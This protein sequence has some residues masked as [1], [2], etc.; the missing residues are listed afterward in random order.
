MPASGQPARAKAPGHLLARAVRLGHLRWYAVRPE[1]GLAFD[2]RRLVIW[3]AAFAIYAGAVTIFSGGGADGTWG[4][5]ATVGYALTADRGDSVRGVSL[6]RSSRRWP[7]RCW[8]PWS[9]WPYA[10]RPRLTSRV[11]THSAVP[12]LRTGSPYLSAGH[13]ATWQTYNP[14]LP[15]MA[16][17]GLPGAIGLP[18][19]SAT[20]GCG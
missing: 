1:H 5:W 12:L 4:A 2:R 14:Y 13:L 6:R 9:G 11:V 8:R 15:A 16:L 3:Y 18:A 17:F 10:T 7:L 20:P 19:C